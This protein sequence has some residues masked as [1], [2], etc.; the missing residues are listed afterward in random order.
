VISL[1]SP[2]PPDI[3]DV[4]DEIFRDGGFL[5]SLFNFEHRGAQQEM[6]LQCAQAFSADYP[7]IFEAGTGVGKSLA[8]LIPGIMA[9]RRFGR[10]LIVSTHTIALQHQIISKELPRIKELFSKTPSLSEFADFKYSILVGRGNY[11]CTTRLK[12]AMAEKMDLFDSEESKELERIAA[13]AVKTQTGLVEELTPEPDWEVWSWVNAD[14]SSCS[15]KKCSDGLCFY[16]N[17]RRRAAQCDVLI[18]NHSLLFSMLASGLG[19]DSETQGVLFARDMCVLDEAHL[20]PDVAAENFGLSLSSGGVLRELKRI[21]DP[22]KRRGLITRGNLGTVWDKKCAEDAIVAAEEFFARIHKK[23]LIK[24][25]TVALNAP[26]W[27]E[28]LLTAPLESLCKALDKLAQNAKSEELSAEIKD[29]KRRL[30]GIRNS[31]EEAIFL[32][33]EKQVYWVEKTGKGGMGVKL[34]SAPLD[35]APILRQVLFAKGVPVILSSATLAT[36]NG[37]LEDF[38][39]KV[40]AE[41]AEKTIC[42]SPFDYAKNMRVII[43]ADSPEPDKESKKLECEFLKTRIEELC[44][45]IPGGALVLFTGY[46][47][48]Q[49]TAELLRRSP[50]MKGRKI[51]A[52]KELARNVLIRE[53]EKAGN[54]VLLGTDSFWTGIDVPGNALSQVIITRLPFDNP[55]HPL[56]AA[57]IDKCVAEGE[58][59]FIKISVPAAIIKFRQGVGRLIRNKTDRGVIS[60][61]DSRILS[62]PYGKRFIAALPNTA[63]TRFDA[64][65]TAAVAARAAQ[66]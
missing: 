61:L 60:I 8:Y 32:S 38:A 10:Q 9:A 42:A 57:R 43:A 21:Y 1:G 27:E 35:V 63:F 20:V 46:S 18:I 41:S 4:C 47:E 26:E 50:H 65:N 33:G 19:A 49:K 5:G 2:L 36:E 45:Q 54:A 7:L 62:K 64:S 11:L 14:A 13:W 34:C 39:S 24:R 58:N 29:Y 17:A 3:P 44:A 15:P 55:Q 28:P 56:L 23:F 59:P 16:Q 25:D 51:F 22:R 40:G 52:Q 12:R 48:L 66:F 53:F 30:T 37:N 31:A 6:A